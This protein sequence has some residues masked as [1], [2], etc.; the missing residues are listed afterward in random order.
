MSEPAND[1]LTRME[2]MKRVQLTGLGRPENVCRVAEVEDVGSPAGTELVVAMKAAAINPADLLIFE[3][4]DT[5]VLVMEY[6]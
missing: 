2:S 6:V 1:K 5:Q 3:K 4:R